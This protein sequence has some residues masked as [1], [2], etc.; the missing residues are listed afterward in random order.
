M[1]RLPRKYFSFLSSAR[2]ASAASP[3]AA[4]AA[5]QQQQEEEEDVPEQEQAME[6]FTWVGKIFRPVPSTQA[7]LNRSKL[8]VETAGFNDE[9]LFKPVVIG[10]RRCMESIGS[11][12]KELQS[13]P[14]ML[15]DKIVDRCCSRQTSG[16][17]ATPHWCTIRPL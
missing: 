16:I 14:L 3:A 15:P 5:A 6:G 8:I 1:P 9:E 12:A 4:A 11:R 10:N 13:S 2:S 7:T 17:D